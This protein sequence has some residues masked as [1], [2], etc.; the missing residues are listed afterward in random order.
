L[1]SEDETVIVAK[2]GR[3]SVRQWLWLCVL[4]LIG[5]VAG[6][7]DS[8]THERVTTGRTS[9]SAATPPAP[10]TRESDAQ[11]PAASP[12]AIVPSAPVAAEEKP[13]QPVEPAVHADTHS[14]AAKPTNASPRATAVTR[15]NPKAAD[16]MAPPTPEKPGPASVSGTVEL[17][18]AVDE[19]ATS[20]DV[21]DA[22]VYFHPAGATLRV[23]PGEYRM[24]THDKQFDPRTLVIPVGSTVV[25]PNQDSILHNVFSVSPIATFDLGY[26]GQGDRRQ[27]TFTRPG[28]ALIYCNVHSRMQA[29]VLVLDTPYFTRPQRDGQFRLSGLPRGE[30]TLTV[31][32]PRAAASSQRIT[33]PTGPL[34]LHLVLSRPRLDPHRNK[35]GQIY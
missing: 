29:D 24:Y 3:A 14:A 33:V 19:P 15:P 2:R 30:G 25:F 34:R 12:P 20:A 8:Q 16:E 27:Y 28:V 31:W 22:V 10:P 1:Q 18:S 6:C 9:P 7:V 35:E 32:H 11:A 26:F 21:L 13:A 23:T 5:S 4:V 17:T